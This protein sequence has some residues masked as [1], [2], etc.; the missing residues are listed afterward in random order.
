[1]LTNDLHDAITYSG[2]LL[3]LTIS[4]YN[5][6]LN[7]LKTAIYYSLTSTPFK[8]GGLLTILNSTSSKSKLQASQ[9]KSTLCCVLG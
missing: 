6:P 8:V 7:R 2:Y 4:K 3:L 1:V 5:F 9:G